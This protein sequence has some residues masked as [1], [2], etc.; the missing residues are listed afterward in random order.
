LHID[1]NSRKRFTGKK[2]R[3]KKVTWCGGGVAAIAVRSG[4]RMVEAGVDEKKRR[5]WHQLGC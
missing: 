5:S 3:E 4:V 2:G 1:D